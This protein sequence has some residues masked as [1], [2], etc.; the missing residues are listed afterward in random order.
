MIFIDKPKTATDTGGTTTNAAVTTDI[1]TTTE[2]YF[3][4]YTTPVA[5]WGFYNLQEMGNCLV[6]IIGY[7]V[8]GSS[9]DYVYT[10]YQRSNITCKFENGYLVYYDFIDWNTLTINWKTINAF[11]CN[12]VNNDYV[13]TPTDNESINIDERKT[14]P[15]RSDFVV[16]VDEG[17]SRT[18]KRWYIPYSLIDWSRGVEPFEKEED[19]GSITTYYKLYL[20]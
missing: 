19:D 14:S 18:P 12:I 6:S 15:Y 17:D 1:S 11:R 8:S 7:N 9:N 5:E 4:P 10:Q 13:D 3:E 16:F 20:K 2:P